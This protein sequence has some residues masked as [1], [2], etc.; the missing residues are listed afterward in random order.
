MGLARDINHI[1]GGRANS[2]L[3]INRVSLKAR[4]VLCPRWAVHATGT[5]GSHDF[6]GLKER[7][8]YRLSDGICCNNII[9][10]GVVLYYMT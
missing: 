10:Y 1:C 4:L 6:A 5:A 9:L 8:R 7:L 3:E 2:A